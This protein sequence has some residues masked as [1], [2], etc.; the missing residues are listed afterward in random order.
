VVRFDT[1]LPRLLTGVYPT[2]REPGTGRTFA[3]TGE[4]LTLRLPGLDRRV[5][6]RLT[7]RVRGARLPPTPNPVLTFLADGVELGTTPTATDYE[8]LSVVVP[9][10]P[11]RRGLTLGVRTS[12]TFVP[13]PADPR[14]LGVMLDELRLSPSGVVV[15]PR[16]AF[17][18]A[19]PAAAAMGAGIAALGV[20]AGSAILAALVV[21]GGISSII[22]RGF[23]P[24]TEFPALAARTGIAVAF[25]LAALAMAVRL[26]MGA[27]LRNTARFVIAFSGCALLLELMVLLHPDMPIGDALFQAHR[28]QDVLAGKLYFTSVAPGNYLF[29]YAPGLYVVA[30]VFSDM[31][32]RGHDDM[33]LLRIV[34]AAVSAASAAL[35]YW[36][37]VRASGDRLAAACAVAICHLIPLSFG[38]LAVGNLTNAFAQSVSVLALVMMGSGSLRRGNLALT[39]LFT[40]VLTLAF[41]SHTSTFAI[42]SAACMCTAVLFWC[43]GAAPVRESGAV[44]AVSL[45]VAVLLAVV[46]YYA[47]FL[48]TYRTELGRIGGETLAA[49]PD[50]G[51]RGSLTRLLNVPRYL[52]IYFGIPALLLAAW[53]ARALWRRGTGQPLPLAI[54]GWTLTCG[55]FLILGIVTPVD[56]RYYLASIPAIAVAGGFGA[57]AGWYAGGAARA[58]SAV[59]LTWA[60]V[61]GVRAWWSTIG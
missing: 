44:V 60:L 42:L 3:W 41:L 58:A 48:E 61:E 20:T 17:A 57:S 18:G 27:P 51:G 49:S 52:R 4:Q 45:G 25:A 33:A 12:A 16:T 47:H 50:A 29:P 7:L 59:L 23:A 40:G 5:E 36:V 53:G 31:V 28:F 39:L 11:D 15:P 14:P 32:P 55:G 34:T 2:E 37:T 8:E 1:E 19:A 46:L 35:L 10:R 6:W 56:M 24:Y 22:A 13:G 54:G 30:S 26:R 38:V 43:R 21:A 9:A